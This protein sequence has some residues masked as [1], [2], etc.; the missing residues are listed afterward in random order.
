[1]RP[2]FCHPAVTHC[3]PSSLS[4]GVRTPEEG[5][6]PSISAPT[7]SCL[8]LQSLSSL[9]PEENSTPG[10]SPS[11]FRP[12]GQAV[13][14]IR[15]T[16]GRAACPG[17]WHAGSWVQ[18]HTRCSSMER[19]T[20][21]IVQPSSPWA[22]HR[23]ACPNLCSALCLAPHPLGTWLSLHRKVSPGG[24]QPLPAFYR[25]GPGIGVFR[26]AGHSLS[27]NARLCAKRKRRHRPVSPR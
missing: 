24:D 22:G 20:R 12:L 8:A 23:R 5:A 9:G 19:W 3:H 7:C 16:A 2:L 4:G 25:G 26:C 10:T 21:R 13:L 27:T 11:L 1:M 14:G 18:L 17:L 6:S 15:E